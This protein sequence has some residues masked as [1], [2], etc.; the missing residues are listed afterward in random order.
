MMT[1][2]AGCA[3]LDTQESIGTNSK[4]LR[5]SRDGMSAQTR[6]ITANHRYEGLY[7]VVSTLVLTCI[8]RLQPVK[9]TEN[10][11]NIQRPHHVQLLVSQ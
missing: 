8:Y 10:Y 9:I 5:L 1:L 11:K 7:C 3:G 2:Y 4:N 6:R